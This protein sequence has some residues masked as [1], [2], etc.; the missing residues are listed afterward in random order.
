M[1]HLKYQDLL[2]IFNSFKYS[3]LFTNIQARSIRQN[4]KSCMFCA[5]GAICL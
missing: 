5:V 1:S 4:I 3:F 2:I